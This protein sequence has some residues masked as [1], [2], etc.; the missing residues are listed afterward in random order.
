M[1]G[2]TH[3]GQKGTLD[4]QA[5]IIVWTIQYAALSEPKLYP[6]EDQQALLPTVPSPQLIIRPIF[7]LNV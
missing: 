6:P 4:S 5:E 1:C 7:S 2:G 3:G